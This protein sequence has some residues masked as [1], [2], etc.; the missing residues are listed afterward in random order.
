MVQTRQMAKLAAK[1][2]RD[3]LSKLPNEIL[4]QA[5]S[6]LSIEEIAKAKEI[7][8]RFSNVITSIDTMLFRPHAQM[9]A[10]KL[11]DASSRIMQTDGKPRTFYQQLAIFF[12]HRG[13]QAKRQLRKRDLNVFVR[14]WQKSHDPLPDQADSRWYIYLFAENLLDIH[15]HFQGTADER[16]SYEHLV[17]TSNFDD[18][19]GHAEDAKI[20]LPW[21][22][23]QPYTDKNQSV[24]SLFKLIRDKGLV[25]PETGA[26][27]KV[28]RDSTDSGAHLPRYPLTQLGYKLVDEEFKGM[29]DGKRRRQAGCCSQQRLQMVL[30]GSDE[31]LPTLPW[32]RHFAYCVSDSKTYR[33]FLAERKAIGK[34]VE[35]SWLFRA[36]LVERMFLY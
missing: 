11:I 26:V 33:A 21:T 27:P 36:R 32:T 22:T 10:Q 29:R 15:V 30:G 24:R 2:P 35:T 12:S 34:G 4:T 18:L 7:S 3:R 23:K 8:R 19:A 14:Q 31:L 13:I 17:I 5:L 28:V 1:A 9:A 6:Y 25:D 20:H 16:E